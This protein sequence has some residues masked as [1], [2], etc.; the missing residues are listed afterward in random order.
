MACEDLV[1]GLG[2]AHTDTD[3]EDEDEDGDSGVHNTPDYLHNEA[4]AEASLDILTQDSLY[5][6]LKYQPGKY[7]LASCVLRYL[8]RDLFKP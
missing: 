8:D 6:S 5:E 4:E 1:A 2:E 7:L 3:T